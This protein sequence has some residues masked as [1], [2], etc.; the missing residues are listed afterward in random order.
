MKDQNPYNEQ[1]A[2]KAIAFVCAFGLLSMIVVGFGIIV[3]FVN[4]F[5]I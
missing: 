4:Y 3:A 1:S 5:C 2:G